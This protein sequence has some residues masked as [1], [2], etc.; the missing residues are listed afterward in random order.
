MPPHTLTDS[1]WHRVTQQCWRRAAR[2]CGVVRQLPAAQVSAAPRQADV[3]ANRPA[4]SHLLQQHSAEDA[5]SQV[6][7]AFAEVEQPLRA[8]LMVRATHGGRL[9]P[10]R[11]ASL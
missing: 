4:L 9:A 8:A 2:A 5:T 6:I 10:G 7:R 3:H 11:A 1:E